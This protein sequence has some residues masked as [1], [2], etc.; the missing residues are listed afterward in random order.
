MATYAEV[1]AGVYATVAAHAQHQD[2][3]DTDGIMALY[4]PDAVLEVPGM[5]SYEGADAIR[6]AWDDWKPKGPQR[7]MPVNIVITGWDDEEARATTD[8]VFLARGDNGWSV[9]IVARYHDAF[10]RVGGKWLLSR[11]A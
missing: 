3:G 1:F 4:T 5:G 8:V 6:A 10:R 2:A 7:H 9:Q 11:R